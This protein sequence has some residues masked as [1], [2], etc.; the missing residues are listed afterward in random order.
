LPLE[1]S[2]LFGARSRQKPSRRLAFSPKAKQSVEIPGN[3]QSRSALL[4]RQRSLSL[5]H[6]DQWL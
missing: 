6:G 3:F 1:M 4:G 5:S 2:R